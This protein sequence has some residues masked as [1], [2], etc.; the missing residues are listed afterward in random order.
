MRQRVVT[1]ILFTVGVLLFVIPSYWIPF[2]SVVFACVVGGF[3]TH[4]LYNAFRAG[5]MQPLL[6]LMIIGGV[7]TPLHVLI[8]YFFIKDINLS[9]VLF[10]VILGMICFI[11]SVI[12]SVIHKDGEGRLRDGVVTSAAIFYYC[13]PLFCLMAGMLLAENGWYYMVFGLF[14][15]W[16]S[17]TCAYFVGVT[18][19]KHKIVPHISPKKTWEGCIGGA[20]GC[21]LL[22]MLYL[23][24]IVYKVD[25]LTVNI[26][27]FAVI[28]FVFGLIISVMSQLGDWLASLI[29]RLVG[30]KDYGKIFPGHGGMLDR[31]DSVFFT[32]PVGFLLAILANDFL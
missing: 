11:G 21:A 28:A 15:S 20:L 10:F 9:S 16:V 12:P 8:S 1:G 29:K 7:F 14:S 6:P 18:I 24:L 31:F 5:K 22:V 30:I 19:G 32:L 23:T 13:F 25:N 27:V 2:I 3:V 26:Y 17:D 4:E